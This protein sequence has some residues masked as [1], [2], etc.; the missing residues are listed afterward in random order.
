MN[1]VLN[2][3]TYINIIYNNNNIPPLGLWLVRVVFDC[4]FVCACLS[5]Y[6]CEWE[7]ACL[8][9]YVCVVWVYFCVWDFR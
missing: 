7:Y 9:V 5:D 1:F 2:N 4:W 3:K 6:V 8:F